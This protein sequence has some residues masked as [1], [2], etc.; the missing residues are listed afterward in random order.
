MVLIRYDQGNYVP[1]GKPIPT[2]PPLEG[3]EHLTFSPFK[4]EIERG[5]SLYSGMKKITGA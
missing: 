5:M 1:K 2:V 3:E 4:V